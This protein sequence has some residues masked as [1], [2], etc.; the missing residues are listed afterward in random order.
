MGLEPCPQ[1]A[2]NKRRRARRLLLELTE[3]PPN[4]FHCVQCAWMGTIVFRFCI[5]D[6]NDPEAIEYGN[7]NNVYDD[8]KH[9]C[10]SQR[11]SEHE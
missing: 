6:S 11:C 9:N 8:G 7:F 5:V 3:V 1:L 10:T 2:I 4:P